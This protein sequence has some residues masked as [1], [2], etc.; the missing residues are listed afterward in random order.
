MVVPIY[1]NVKIG[2]SLSYK[3]VGTWKNPVK[4]RSLVSTGLLIETKI[5]SMRHISTLFFCLL[6]LSTA[7]YAQDS[8]NLKIQ[9]LKIL[10]RQLP[11]T[12]PNTEPVIIRIR[13]GYSN[14]CAMPLIV[15][16]G[17]VAKKNELK[18]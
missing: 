9:G 17:I 18:N 10:S 6:L 5:K 2:A 3:L 1:V 12:T 16:D 7:V 15:I 11:I 4:Y 8:S 13:C 14:S